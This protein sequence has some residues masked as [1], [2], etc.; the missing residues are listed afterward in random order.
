VTGRSIFPFW[1]IYANSNTGI[2]GSLLIYDHDLKKV[3]SQK[4]YVH[5]WKMEKQVGLE[6]LHHCAEF[7]KSWVYTHAR[8]LISNWNCWVDFFKSCRRVLKKNAKNWLQLFWSPSRIPLLS[9]SWQTLGR[10]ISYEWRC[11]VN[12][13]TVLTKKWSK[14]PWYCWKR[15]V[16][17]SLQFSPLLERCSSCLTYLAIPV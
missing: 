16:A 4:T 13:K 14:I 17:K 2:K 9:S 5:K 6:L 1:N 10:Y 7:T 15:V 8:G 12:L 11:L 3:T